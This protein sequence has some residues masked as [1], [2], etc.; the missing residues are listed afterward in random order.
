MSYHAHLSIVLHSFSV[1]PTD[2]R[3]KIKVIVGSKPCLL[4]I[5]EESGQASRQ[6][7]LWADVFMLIF[8][9]SSL[10]SLEALDKLHQEFQ[11]HRADNPETIV[12]LVGV[13]GGSSSCDI[14]VIFM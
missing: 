13:V 1:P 4:L 9:Y 7:S 12:M 3:Y 5:R 8:S 11:E 6:L 10:S 2:G 14:H